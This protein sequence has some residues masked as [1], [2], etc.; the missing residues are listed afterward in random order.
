MRLRS[1]NKFKHFSLKGIDENLYRHNLL[2]KLEKYKKVKSVKLLTYTVDRFS[3]MIERIKTKNYENNR[4]VDI[5]K[6][7]QSHMIETLKVYPYERIKN[8]TW[9]SFSKFIRKPGTNLYSWISVFTVFIILYLFVFYSSMEDSQETTSFLSLENF[10]GSMLVILFLQVAI[11][12]IDRYLYLKNPLS[13]RN[14][15][16]FR[17]TEVQELRLY[18]YLKLKNSHNDRPIEK[19]TK[20]VRKLRIIFLFT[21]N[22]LDVDKFYKV[23]ETEKKIYESRKKQPSLNDDYKDNPLLPRM[24]LQMAIMVVMYFI[25]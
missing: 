25:I 3:S 16:I 13:W 9:R 22:K 20:L 6:V 19:F 4:F 17:E 15:E 23:I 24:Y 10:P 2:Q 8:T 12:V 11:L 7:I 5:I 1:N 18:E 14:W 21:Q